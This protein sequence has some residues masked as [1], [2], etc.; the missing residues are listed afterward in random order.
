MV[1]SSSHKSAGTL[2]LASAAFLLSQEVSLWLFSA[3][4]NCEPWGKSPSR[5][6]QLSW[7]SQFPFTR[8]RQSF[9]DH[10]GLVEEEVKET[11]SCK[12]QH[13]FKLEWSGQIKNYW[14]T[15]PNCVTMKQNAIC[16]KSLPVFKK[17]DICLSLLKFWCDAQ[18]NLTP[19]KNYFKILAVS[20]VVQK[21]SIPVTRSWC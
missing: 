19:I 20:L 17:G 7:K 5:S 15:R 4:P 12:A 10:Q 11:D 21:A 13:N 8:W 18:S 3:F 14:C 6:C 16:D 1:I 9:G 2:I